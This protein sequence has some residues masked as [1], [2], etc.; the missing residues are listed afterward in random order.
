MN[1]TKTKEKE[2]PLEVM[3]SIYVCDRIGTGEYIEKIV[4][5]G[6]KKLSI[7]RK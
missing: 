6:K 7:K 4:C 5:I 2:K 3:Y 1:K